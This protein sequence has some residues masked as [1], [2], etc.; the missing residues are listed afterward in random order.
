MVMASEVCS[1]VPASG[2]KQHT[3]VDV[4]VTKSSSGFSNH[5]WSKGR[6]KMTNSTSGGG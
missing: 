6:T 2:P 4:H 5:D 1:V 3:H